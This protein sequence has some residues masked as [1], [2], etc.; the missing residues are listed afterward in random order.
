[1]IVLVPL[2]KPVAKPSLPKELLTVAAAGFDE[3]Q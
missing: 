1:M 2:L 3:L